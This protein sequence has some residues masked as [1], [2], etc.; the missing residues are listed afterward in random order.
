[1]KYPLKP[2]DIASQADI[3]AG[4]VNICQNY[5]EYVRQINAAFYTGY[6]MAMC[7]TK[8]EFDSITTEDRIMYCALAKLNAAKFYGLDEEDPE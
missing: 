3:A 7:D 6:M 5:M 1:M 4:R 8:E 2:S